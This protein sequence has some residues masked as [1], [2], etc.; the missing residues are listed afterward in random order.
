MKLTIAP[1]QPLSPQDEADRR[2]RAEDDY[3]FNKEEND[4]LNSCK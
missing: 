2:I 3:W 1:I 4:H